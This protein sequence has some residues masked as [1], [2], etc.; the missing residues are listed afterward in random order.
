MQILLL[1]PRLIAGIC[2]GALGFW[3]ASAAYEGG[4]DFAGLPAAIGLCGMV[5]GCWFI[6]AIARTT[7]MANRAVGY[8]VLIIG[9][10]VVL[11]SSIGNSAKHRSANVGTAAQAI[12][13]YTQAEKDLAR[14]TA[15]LETMQKNPKRPGEAHPRWIATAGCANATVPESTDYCDNVR[16]VNAALAEARAVLH[17][18]RPLSADPQ[19]ASL[20]KFIDMTPDEINEWIPIWLAIASEIVATGL[21]TLAFAP[22]K[23]SA[24]PQAAPEPQEAPEPAEPPQCAWIAS[25]ALETHPWPA[26]TAKMPF[27]RVDG[28]KLRWLPKNPDLNDNKAA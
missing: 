7:T 5:V 1:I 23:L 17:R 20:R 26:Y 25:V 13:A 2:G 3:C 6:P 24:P 21:M 12:S 11:I 8:F 28:R 9:T 10:V 27:G 14:L 19:A 16:R 18:G 4:H 22:I 15:E